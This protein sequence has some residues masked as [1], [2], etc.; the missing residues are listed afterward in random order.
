MRKRFV[1]FLAILLLFASVCW[2]AVEAHAAVTNVIGSCYISPSG[3]SVTFGG[4]SLSSKTE[5][6]IQVTVILWEQRNGTWY[7][8]A[9]V[10]KSKQNAILVTA[11]K[12]VTVSG[13]YYYKATATHYAQTGS[14]SN[15][16]SSSTSSVWIP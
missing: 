6:T 3:R 13:G 4:R 14:T 7:E 15:T 1:M 10:S 16:S 5:D 2:P 12:T 8:V 11:S 9:R